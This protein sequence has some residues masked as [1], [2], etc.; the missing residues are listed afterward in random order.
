MKAIIGV[1]GFQRGWLET[2][3]FRG[4]GKIYRYTS[5][6]GEVKMAIVKLLKDLDIM[7]NGRCRYVA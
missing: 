6:E 4:E 2:L 1:W 5:I 7:V 3:E